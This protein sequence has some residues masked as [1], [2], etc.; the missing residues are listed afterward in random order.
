[1]KD[2]YKNYHQ[3]FYGAFLNSSCYLYLDQFWSGRTWM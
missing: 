2:S 1:M 3:S